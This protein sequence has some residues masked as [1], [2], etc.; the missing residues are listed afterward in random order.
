MS[1]IGKIIPLSESLLLN[2]LAEVGPK[3]YWIVLAVL[4]SEDMES[5]NVT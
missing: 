5:N 4:F 2:K 1:Q 3:K